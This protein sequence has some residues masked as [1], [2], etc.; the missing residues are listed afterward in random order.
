MR[1]GKRPA[2]K[3]LSVAETTRQSQAAL[4]YYSKL[5]GKPTIDLGPIP[6][7][8]KR[9][10]VR[11]A[12]PKEHQ[13][14]V[15]YVAWFRRT[16]PA[17]L[18]FAIPNGGVRD[19]VTAF[20]LKQEGVEPDVPDLFVPKFRLWVEMKRIGGARRPSQREMA[21]HLIGCGYLHFFGMGAEDAKTK[22]LQLFP[23]EGQP[24]A[25]TEA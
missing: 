17:V 1:Y 4:N 10:P 20:R 13:E 9:V 3:L 15:N 8:K 2:R 7:P 11:G 6:V 19:A 24:N 14:Q 25:A 5:S 23:I 12:P 22:T 18:I 16:Y 21:E